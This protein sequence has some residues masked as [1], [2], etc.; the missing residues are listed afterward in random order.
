MSASLQFEF[1]D[2]GAIDMPADYLPDAPGVMFAGED[3]LSAAGYVPGSIRPPGWIKHQPGCY[4]KRVGKHVLQV[5]QCGNSRSTHWTI[6]R[7]ED[8]DFKWIEALVF[9]FGNAEPIWARAYQA[10]MHLAEYC[11]PIARPPVFAS[12]EVA[13]AKVAGFSRSCRFAA[14]KVKYSAPATMRAFCPASHFL[15][16]TV[17]PFDR[18]GHS[19]PGRTNSKADGVRY[20]RKSIR[21]H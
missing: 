17:S 9:S 21:R 10:A 12:W 7:F 3:I 20:A 6:E 19:Q 16:G 2:R 18:M 14:L 8:L 15:S 11:Y 1:L 13:R 4:R 5:R